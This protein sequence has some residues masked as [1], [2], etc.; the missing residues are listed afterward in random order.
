MRHSVKNAVDMGVK[1]SDGK[2]NVNEGGLQRPKAGR[3]KENGNEFPTQLTDN[4]CLGLASQASRL[5]LLHVSA[6][7][8]L[9]FCQVDS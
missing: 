4:C 8:L 9:G 1:K 3:K 7:I 6:D 5:L 2:M